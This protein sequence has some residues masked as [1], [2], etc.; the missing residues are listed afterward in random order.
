MCT[1]SYNSTNRKCPS[2]L[3]TASHTK[4]VL[5]YEWRIPHD[6]EEKCLFHSENE[7]FKSRYNITEYFETLVRL[8]DDI[9]L[10]ERQQTYNFRGFQ[11]L[12][13]YPES[14][15][16]PRD[17]KSKAFRIS[18][19]TFS[20][21]LDFSESIFSSPVLFKDCQIKHGLVLDRAICKE[22]LSVLDTDVYDFRALFVKAK[23]VN[24]KGSN[25]STHFAIDYAEIQDT[26]NIDSCTF[27]SRLCSF[28]GVQI[29][30]GK[31]HLHYSRIKNST[32]NA[33]VNFN[34]AKIICFFEFDS[35]K[36]YDNVE[37]LNSKFAPLEERIDQA[38][39]SFKNVKLYKNSEIRFI[40]EKPYDNI[41]QSTTKLDIEFHENSKCLFENV[42]FANIQSETKNLIFNNE[43]LGKVVI[44]SGCMKYRNIS[45]EI[46]VEKEDIVIQLLEDYI[47]IFLNALNITEGENFNLGVEVLERKSNYIRYIFFSDE[48]LNGKTID[49]IIGEGKG[50]LVSVLSQNPITKKS[51]VEKDIML[52]FNYLL[53]KIGMLQ[54][55][56]YEQ[57]V[58]DFITAFSEASTLS[59]VD[60]QLMI[61]ISLNN[62]SSIK[63]IHNKINL[64]GDYATIIQGSDNNN[65][66]IENKR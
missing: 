58:N 3:I 15:N 21:T 16:N 27:R 9:Y 46:V 50:N 25:F 60:K 11:I 26:L 64:S 7:F 40:G 14:S 23:R 4:K 1:Y 5:G 18:N 33:N 8:L 22:N 17:H 55:T 47:D 12:G 59:L 20:Y 13:D 24:L 51:L 29:R 41:F 66:S 35:V 52:K 10:S 54:S 63:N 31:I 30:P 65:I 43:K 19:M 32:F 48:Y 38:S 2:E 53:S 6:T 42:N 45:S 49:E 39:F 62:Y 36:F 56:G 61:N 57:Q 37:F 44:G 34:N 28:D